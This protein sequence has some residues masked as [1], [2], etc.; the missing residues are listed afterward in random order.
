MRKL[1]RLAEVTTADVPRA[2]RKAAVLGELIR[3]GFA[4]PD[5]VVLTPSPDPL[6]CA[7]VRALL[8]AVR[9]LGDGSFAVRSSGV[10]EDLADRSYAGAYQ[11]VLGVQGEKALAEAV[12]GV[13]ASAGDTNPM[14]VLVQRMVPA[15]AAGVAFTVNPVTGETEVLL[16]AVEGLADRLVS[17]EID[18]DE[19]IVR[20][21]SARLAYGSGAAIT[22]AQ[23]VE[24]SRVAERVAGRFGAPQDIEWAIAD[25]ELYVLQARPVTAARW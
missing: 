20:D 5:G 22:A 12:L 14:A 8:D 3:D 23:A 10:A 9:G 24:V 25:D 15:D 16:N 2:G 4:V 19:W 1:L 18:P 11:T 17:G 7:E 21:H 13:L 6:T